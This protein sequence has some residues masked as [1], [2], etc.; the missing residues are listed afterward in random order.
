MEILAG[1]LTSIF[2]GGATGLLGMALQ[3]FFDWLKVKQDLQLFDAKAS[4]E[5]AMRQQDAIIMREEW[6][7]RFKVA[8]VEGETKKDVAENQSFQASLLREPERYSNVS[9]LTARQ[10]WVMVTLDFARGIVRP[11]LTVYL[12]ALTTYIWW[13]VRQLLSTEDLEV[14]DVLAVWKTVVETILYLT[15]TVVLWWFGT[16]NKASTPSTRLG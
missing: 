10:Q 13:Q 8:E 15:T 4:H 2:T 1:L 9:T 7:G 11:M 16:R 14:S 12:C 6:A 3:R 5:I